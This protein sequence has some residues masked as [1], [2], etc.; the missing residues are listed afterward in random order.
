M[1]CRPQSVETTPIPGMVVVRLDVREDARGWFKEN[2]QREKMVALGLPDF[3][4]VQNNISFN[5]TAGRDPRHPRRAVGQVRLRRHRPGLR[6][7]GRPARGRLVR[8]GVH[9]RDHARGSRSS[10][11]AGSATPSRPSRTRTSYTYLVNDHWRPARR[12]PRWPRRPHRRDRLA[13]PA[14][15]RRALREGPPP[16]PAAGRRGPDGAAAH[17]VVLGGNGQL[18][19]ALA[20][21]TARTPTWSTATGSTSPTPG[22]GGLAVDGLRHRPQRRRLDG[23]RRGRGRARPGAWAAN[24]AAPAPLAR[25]AREHRLTLVHYSTDYVFDGTVERHTEDE[26]VSPLGCLRPV[27]GGR[28]ARG[29][30][31]AAA[32]RAAHLVGDRRRQQLRADDGLARRPGRLARAWST[33]ST[34]G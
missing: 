23:R 21:R 11:R 32:L 29:R 5:A 28:R 16:E 4:P 22:A 8:R 1:A 18:G 12:T 10:S 26:P 14:R 13:D 33:T 6:R 34:A 30:H 7:L 31:G 2:W 9:R 27:Q 24:A 20:A 25:I 17:P 19:R 3:G 15:R